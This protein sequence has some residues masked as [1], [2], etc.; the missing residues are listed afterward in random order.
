MEH[1]VT[2]RLELSDPYLRWFDARVV[3]HRLVGDLHAV[4]LDRSAFY[5]GGGGQPADGGSISGIPLL[6]VRESQGERL[7]L[8]PELPPTLDVACEL[9]WPRRFD[10]MQQH[11]GAHL[12]SRAFASVVRASTDSFRIAADR[13]VFEVAA[14]IERVQPALAAVEAIANE[15]V[16]S[17][18]E[19]EVRQDGDVHAPSGETLRVVIVGGYDA[20]PCGGTHPRRTGEVG[21]IGLLGVKRWGNGTRVEFVCGARVLASL[22]R[23]RDLLDETARSLRSV[24]A[25]IAARVTQVLEVSRAAQDE[26]AR[27]RAA[28]VELEAE[29]LVAAAPGGPAV[30]AMSGGARTLQHLHALARAVAA[31]GRVALLGAVLEDGKAHLCFVRPREGVGSMRR[32]LAAAVAVLGGRG[33]GSDEFAHGAGS[34]RSRL[35]EALATALVAMRG[36]VPASARAPDVVR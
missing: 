24:P 10:H 4:V 18:L 13:S 2:D 20:T 6:D 31:H 21:A 36:A 8:L 22:A 26:A 28:L 29:R 9:D 16:W 15:A 17:N 14:P 32:A 25:E 35:D 30:S 1:F 12:L 33:G 11:H 27:L 7:H 5:P 34:D 23:Q 3:S 19:I